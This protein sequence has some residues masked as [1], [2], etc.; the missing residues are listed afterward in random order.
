MTWIFGAR[1][2]AER[3][4]FK[5]GTATRLTPIADESVDYIYTDPPYGSKIPYLDLSV[6]W[7]AWLEFPVTEEDY[8]LEVVEGGERHKTRNSY[9]Q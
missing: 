2:A 4:I 1:E 5:K 9:A 8:Q 3:A 6:I 7:N